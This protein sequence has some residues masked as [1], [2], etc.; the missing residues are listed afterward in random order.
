MSRKSIGT[1]NKQLIESFLETLENDLNITIL[2]TGYGNSYFI[3][4]GEDNSIC[5]FYI[6]EIP[7]FKFGVWLTS[8]FDNIKDC[9]ER[10]TTLW[11]D[12][13]YVPTRSELV[14]FAQYELFIDKFKPSTSNFI[15]GTF[16]EDSNKWYMSEAEDMLE[17]MIKHH[18]QSIFYSSTGCKFIWDKINIFQLIYITSKDIITQKMYDYKRERNLKK[19][20][21]KC[22]HIVKKINCFDYIVI[23]HRYIASP[24]YSICFCRKNIYDNDKYIKELEYLNKL[25]SK[26]DNNISIG[27]FGVYSDDQNEENY[28]ENKKLR[29]K[30]N[31]IIKNFKKYLDEDEMI[32]TNIKELEIWL[33]R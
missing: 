18:F 5:E 6:K 22:L 30:F 12:Y 10:N 31:S 24:K 3:F 29:I 1:K 2:N 7:G 9:L 19:A 20:A 32:A 17:F 27:I 15:I 11:S 21:K 13:L 23:K 8:R 33:Y 28:K 4:E 14:L 26:Y 25:E 16:R